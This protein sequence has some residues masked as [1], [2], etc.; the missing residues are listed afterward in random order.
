MV[1]NLKSKKIIKYLLS[2]IAVITMLFAFS[3]AANAE[4]YNP[5]KLSVPRISQRPY[6]GDCAIASMSTVE[7]YFHGL[8]SGDY[9]ST[10]YQAVYSANGYSISA[11]WSK[12]GYK[13]VEYFS[14]QEAY[15]QLKTGTPVIVH[16]TSNHYSVI[17]GY[18][19]S[20]TSLSKSGFLVCDVDDSYNSST[21]YMRLDTWQRGG[22]DRMVIRVDGLT[23][24]TGGLKIN[25]NH[26]AAHHE[27][28]SSF[29]PHGKVISNYNISN[30]SVAIKTATGAGIY[31]YS[32][33]PNT[34][35][36]ALSNASS[37]I[38]AAKLNTGNYVYSI[39]AKDT[40][41]ATK[42]Y[43]YSFKVVSG[44]Y[45]PEDYVAPAIKTVSYKAVVTA[46]PCLNLRK[47][48]GLDY[49][50]I[51]TINRNEKVDVTAECGDW[52]TVKYKGYVGW[53]S[54]T[55]LEKY[56]EPAIETTTAVT[57]V[58]DV[59]RYGRTTAKVSLRKAS[60]D[61]STTLVSIPKNSIVRILKAEDGWYKVKYN[62]NT[63]YIK[64][65]NCVA[66]VFDVDKNSKITASDALMA[67]KA[68]V[69]STS[70]TDAQKKRADV[71]GNGKIDCSD[72]LAILQVVT[73]KKSY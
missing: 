67:I 66:D 38:L 61:S 65:K 39:Y 57:T 3:I 40:S 69:K 64:S 27:K 1:E 45:I 37:K 34:T 28:G 17:Y 51:T 25:T 4:T 36:F 71:D 49:D 20:T 72:S 70:L 55:Y 5:I 14:M 29:T 52:A 35:S 60:S 2:A 48:A 47:G 32:A 11:M 63:G 16:R 7:A 22:L 19:G 42:T 54:M 21:A 10:A 62:D 9:N 73:G 15:D 56:V 53:V 44:S 8:P 33:T 43:N 13:T 41:G 46:D 59:I 23:I 26:P 68:T 12:L 6:T 30:V 50:V 31:S 58:N 24:K 18:D